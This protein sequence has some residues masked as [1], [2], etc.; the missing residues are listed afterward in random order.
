MP[1]DLETLIDMGFPEKKARKA[2]L[3]TN[4]GG[5]QAAMDWIL[6][7][8]EED[9][10]KTEETE[11]SSIEKE[12][13]DASAKSLTCDDCGKSFRSPSD[14][15]AHA[16]R[17]KHANFS[18]STEEV[19]PLTKEEKEA[20][21]ARI[22]ER[23][24]SR[25]KERDEKE[26]QERKN[27][28]KSRRHQGQ[29]LLKAKQKFEEDEMK[30]IADQKRREREEDKRARQRVKDLIE[31]DKKARAA[32][33]KK[34]DFSASA[35]SNSVT[36]K[37]VVVEPPEKKEYAECRLQIRLT[38]GSALTHTFKAT[39]SLAAVRLFVE[40][41]RTDG[42]G[43]FSLMTTF[44]KKV[45]TDEDMEKPLTQLGLIPSAVLIVAKI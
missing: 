42:E 17:T 13:A 30:R 1:N 19:R 28:E 45:F 5:V 37:P 26:E 6:E 3:K 9:D 24:V 27:K 36:A 31:Q 4:N 10:D 39:E 21:L 32:K 43:P 20:Q 35:D 38:N 29:D 12:G 25:R 7:H 16:I 15:E 22:Q 44:P 34:E 18:E 41:N 40:I 2:L 8:G 23:L 14:A 11:A 33:A